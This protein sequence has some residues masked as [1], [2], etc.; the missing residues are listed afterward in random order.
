MERDIASL[1]ATLS[2]ANFNPLAPC[3]ARRQGN[4]PVPSGQRFQSTRSV[5]S[6][7]ALCLEMVQIAEFQ[8]TRS[9]WSETCQE[10][11]P[12]I[13]FFISIHSLRVERDAIDSHPPNLYYYFNPLAPC[14]ARPSTTVDH[15][16]QPYFNPLAPCGAR[17][18]CS[19][20]KHSP[21]AI[22]IHSLRVERD[23]IQHTLPVKEVISIHSLRVERDFGD[24]EN[25]SEE[26]ISIHSLR[27]ERDMVRCRQS[28]VYHRFQST[29]S[30]WSETHY[31]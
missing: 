21:Q 25:E 22:S 31:I 4:V 10:E 5:W 13:L 28:R 2:G 20:I 3:G 30:V 27:V 1:I 15:R 23:S 18:G 19:K 12:G 29:R 8:S 7:T 14:G 17:R 24:P 6:E 11:I 16:H 9:V 26:T